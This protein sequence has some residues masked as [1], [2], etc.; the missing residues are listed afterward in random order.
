MAAIQL[1][2]ACGL[3]LVSSDFLRVLIYRPTR[4]GQLSWLLACVEWFRPLRDSNPGRLQ[5]RGFIAHLII[6]AR[7][8]SK[9]NSLDCLEMSNIPIVNTRVYICVGNY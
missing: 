2:W 9:L 3:R 6:S 5:P 1:M 4:D 7:Q 8:C